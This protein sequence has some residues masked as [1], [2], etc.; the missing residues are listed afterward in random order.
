MSGEGSASTNHA[1]VDVLSLQG[2]KATLD[3]RKGEAI[4]IRTV[5][6]EQIGRTAPKLGNLPDADYV[7]QRYLD[8]YDQH[9]DRISR[10]IGA[11]EATQSA[12]TTIIENYETDEALR[13]ADA[14]KIADV[15]GAVSGVPDGDRTNA[16]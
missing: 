11:I 13:V 8:L 2:F 10:V 14:K 16:G 12:I 6:T 1:L 4:A 15:L 3:A 7:G 5:L 9:L